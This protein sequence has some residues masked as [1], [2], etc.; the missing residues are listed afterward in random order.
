M[1]KH[2]LTFIAFAASL[3]LTAQVPVQPLTADTTRAVRHTHLF[4]LGT[5]NLLDTYLSPLEYTGATLSTLHFN[6]RRLSRRSPSWRIEGIYGLN[7]SGASSPTEDADYLDGNIMAACAVVRT[8]RAGSRWLLAAGPMADLSAGFTYNTR[9]GNNPAQA[10]LA[11]NVGLS[12][13]AEHAFR[14]L[15]KEWL[16][17]LRADLPAA[18]LMFSPRYGQSYYEIISLGKTDRN[19]RATTFVNTPSMRFSAL[20]DI[21]LGRTRLTAGFHSDVVQSHLNGLKRHSWQNSFVLG[22][23]RRVYLLP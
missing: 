9:N 13:R 17:R 8:W 19:V 4:G 14:L 3:S 6:E 1:K 23:S 18:G 10:R 21:P 12:L 11:S 20:I 16:L 7:F 5:A 15:H 22:W 2:L